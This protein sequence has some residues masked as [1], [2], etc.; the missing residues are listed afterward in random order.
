MKNAHTKMNPF[1]SFIYIVIAVM[2][3]STFTTD[4]IKI[5]KIEKYVFYSD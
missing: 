5:I 2:F 4:H 1:I 3:S